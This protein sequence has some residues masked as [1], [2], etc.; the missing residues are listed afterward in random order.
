MSALP[1][2]V[3]AHRLGFIQGDASPQYDRRIDDLNKAL[4]AMVSRVVAERDHVNSRFRPAAQAEARQAIEDK[5]YPQFLD[6]SQSEVRFVKHHTKDGVSKATAPLPPVSL[7]VPAV[8][9]RYFQHSAIAGLLDQATHDKDAETA[10]RIRRDLLLAAA[11]SGDPSI[12][13]AYHNLPLVVQE[14]M[15]SAEDIRNATALWRESQQPEVF[16]N[17]RSAASYLDTAKFNLIIAARQMH[18]STRWAEDEQ[19]E[20]AVI[21]A[22]SELNVLIGELPQNAPDLKTALTLH[23]L[24]SPAPLA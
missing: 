17:L 3:E 18:I 4:D 14:S 7:E 22:I 21:S 16:K 9:N 13:R 1:N 5:A 24:A 15:F 10:Y 6:L 11:G 8:M 23:G 20:P 2:L 12:I 19:G